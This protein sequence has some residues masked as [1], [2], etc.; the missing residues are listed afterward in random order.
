MCHKK[1]K[2]LNK[3]C[4]CGAD[5]DKLKR[6]KER[7]KY[8]ND[9]RIP[10]KDE[11]GK[12]K[13]KQRR[14]CVGYSIEDA[15]A[16]DGKRKTQKKENRIFDM[17][18]GTD[19]TFNE[20]AG[21]YLNLES[22]KTNR[23]YDRLVIG[24]GNFNKEF[25]H[26]F[27]NDVVNVDLENY[28]LLRLKSLAP[29]TVDYEVSVAKTMVKKAF[30]NK[31]ISGDA[32]LA[33]QGI[34]K[35]LKKGA[36][37]RKRIA[38]IEE[39]VSLVNA[40]AEHL[41][42]VIVAAFNTGMRRGELRKLRWKYVDFDK[43]FIRLPAEITK[44]KKPKAIPMNHHVLAVLNRLRPRKPKL[45]DSNYHDYVFTYGGKPIKDP[46]GLKRA[47]K[48]SCE[49]GGI[50]YGRKKENGL[51]FHD[52]RATI[53]TNMVEAGIQKEYRDKI[54]GHSGAKDMDRYYLRI[55]EADLKQA[56]DDYTE[57][58]D[59]ELNK[60]METDNLVNIW[61]TKA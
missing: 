29:S 4:V 34:K 18:P 40:A 20:L 42:P 51:C 14:E 46:S 2:R 19:L 43:G 54:L 17:L 28:Q 6:Q 26:K 61:S 7:V 55:R 35:T 31:K 9:F 56:M 37:A 24:L 49:R 27:V 45:K 39:Y 3:K 1:Q 21:W 25:G 5:L 22:V 60:A 12:T 23:A 33:F 30:L 36:N 32:I 8:W 52:F 59:K 57:W 16:A 13:Y 48:A 15:K 38:S 41:K 58:L 47:F 50:D 53:K 11:N 10:H 44:E